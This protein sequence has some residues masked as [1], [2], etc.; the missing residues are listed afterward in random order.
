MK[1][2]VDLDSDWKAIVEQ[3]PADWRELAE[4]HG[5]VGDGRGRA[6]AKLTDPSDALRAI[7]HH[8]CAGSPLRVTTALAAAIGLVDITAVALHKWMRKSGP[9]LAAILC[10]LLD[11]NAAFR[12]ER[13]AGYEVIAADG[14]TTARPGAKSAS[15]RVHW[16][17]RLADLVPIQL[18]VT[19]TEAGETLRR[20]NIRK[21]QLWIVDRGFS[22]VASIAYASKR[23]ADVLVRVNPWS[24]PLRELD[25]TAI[26][27]RARLE[28]S[29][30]RDGEIGE[31]TV[32]SVAKDETEVHGRMVVVRLPPE[33]EQKALA[34]LAREYGKKHVPAEGAKLA[35]YVV[36]FT[37]VPA[38]RLSAEQLIELYRLRW[39]VELDIKRGKSIRDL[40]R[41]PN[42]RADTIYTW[43]CA[44]L[45]GAEIAR[46]L[47]VGG[48]PFP[49]EAI[50]IFAL[51]P[52][53]LAL[54]VAPGRA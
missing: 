5:V 4:K 36:L 23:G 30:R 26:D 1:A 43:I 47:S 54:G 28:S 16:A 6:S 34:R 19:G 35:K 9:W 33:M 38:D 3:L 25:G 49:P 39:Q 51:Y 10:E 44:K 7:L 15:A 45:L 21:R 46:R 22:N 41:L 37:T 31:W 42:S 8:V 14:T 52:G 12:A 11:T 20:F 17:L 18:L 2:T 48:E 53:P 32:K 50:G 27:L 24:L 13:W 29:L 40:D